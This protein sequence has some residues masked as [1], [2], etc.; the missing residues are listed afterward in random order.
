VRPPAHQDS[1]DKTNALAA[2]WK[3]SEQAFH[4]RRREQNRA[5]WQRW[6]LEQAASLEATAARLTAKHL[7]AAAALTKEDQEDDG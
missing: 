2:R 6:H 5:A 3:A 7:A 4:D 1:R